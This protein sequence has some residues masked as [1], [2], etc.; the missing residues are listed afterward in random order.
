MQICGTGSIVG[1]AANNNLD[2]GAGNDTLTGGAG[3]DLFFYRA[4][5]GQDVI[6]DFTAGGAVDEIYF[7]LAYVR[8]FY[9][10]MSF[11]AQ[12]GADTVFDFGNGQLLTLS[13]VTLEDLTADDF[14]FSNPSPPSTVA[15]SDIAL[16][17]NPIAE[18]AAGAIIGAL[19]VTDAD[20][21]IAFAFT[22]SD[23]RFKVVT[24]ANGSRLALKS[25]V[26]LD[27]ET[28]SSVTVE[29]TATDSGGLSYKEQFNITV[30]DRSGAIING[31]SGN[32][33]INGTQTVSGQSLASDENDTINGLAGNDSLS[34]LGGNDTISGGT[35]ND[36]INGGEG[37]DS[38]YGGA[39]VD[40]ING[41]VGN[42][43]IYI[44]GSEAISDIMLGGTGEDAISVVGKSKVSLEGF[45]ASNSIESW[46]G[47]NT[48]VVGTKANNT[49]D[50]SGLTSK[51]GIA[52][53]D[54][55]AG[56]DK[57]TGSLQ[58][59]DI[60]GGDGND[61]L[62]GGGGND[63]LTGGK[64]ADTFVFNGAFGKDTISGF[65]AGAKAGHDVIEFDHNQ[66]A[67]FADVM[68]HAAAVGK[69]VVITLDADHT[70]TLQAMTLSKLVT[71]DFH[72]V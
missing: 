68:N 37:N 65:G 42:D 43:T 58:A 60:R 19:A 45:S 3:D 30:L 6:T 51:T 10:A 5:G 72:F 63:L 1:N 47:N 53:I 59:D 12:D 55:G 22:V 25:G 38:I 8:M 2:G 4:S 41:G 70:V 56:N 14:A 24:D 54:G 21:E 13:D 28:E 7:G 17:A 66:F 52:Y 69:N 36:A 61:T 35:G 18:N 57:I 20:G 27:Y 9:Q 11:A 64:G 62:N 26:S 40:N 50:F 33:T 34:G 15:P 32:D 23:D 67:D 31:T 48:A 29:I 39:G 49:L 46:I 71:S 16:A 44:T